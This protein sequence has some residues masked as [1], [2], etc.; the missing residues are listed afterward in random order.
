MAVGWS[1][2]RVSDKLPAA[3]LRF[4]INVPHQVAARIVLRWPRRRPPRRPVSLFFL[5]LALIAVLVTLL[6]ALAGAVFR[7]MRAATS[8]RSAEFTVTPDVVKPGEGMR[9]WAKVVPRGRQ[10]IYV[11][12][13]LTCTMFDHRARHLYSNTHNLTSVYGRTDEFACFVQ[14]GSDQESSWEQ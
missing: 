11:R 2:R 3:G 7:A 4:H 10:P 9:I 13:S 12:A 14:I 1:S 6:I 5:P 8:I